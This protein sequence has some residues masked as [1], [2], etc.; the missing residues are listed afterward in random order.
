[1]QLENEIRN[2]IEAKCEDYY[3]GTTDLSMSKNPMIN[4]YGPLIAEYPR[5]I[6]FGITL[7]SFV[8][9][10]FKISKIYKKTNCHLKFITSH[11]SHLLENKGYKSFPVP[12]SGK[13]DDGNF[14]SLHNL[15]ANMANG[16]NF[17]KWFDYNTRS[18]FWS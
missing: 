7:P 9:N 18:R 11:L 6:S 13:I 14:I 12:K 1:M 4:Q 17:K 10:P 2:I 3:L 15:A 8:D 5:A 16:E